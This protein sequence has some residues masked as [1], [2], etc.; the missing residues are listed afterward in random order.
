MKIFELNFG[1]GSTRMP[2]VRF[3]LGIV[4]TLS[5][6]GYTVIYADDVP[7]G[8]EDGTPL[9][10]SVSATLENNPRLLELKENRSA[11]EKDLDQAKGG[12]YPRVDLNLGYGTESHSDATT[13]TQ[14]TESDFDYRSEASLNLVQPLYQ[15]GETRSRVR[16][17]IAKL[18]SVNYRVYDNA[19]S[20][21]LDAIIA[22]LEVWRQRRLLDLTEQNIKTHEK[23]LDHI[24]E[25]QRA[26]AGS[27]ADVVQT[28][29]RLALTRSS[30]AQIAGALE[31]ARVN[32]IRVVGNAPE[33]L[34]LPKN[35]HLLAPADAEEAIAVAQ[36]CNPK[37]A[38]FS[39]DIRAAKGD[40]DVS[41][42]NYLP[43][44]N[45][46]LS[47][48]YQD[49]VESSTT[50]SHNNAAMIRARW[51]LFNGGADRAGR[52][53]ATSRKRQ[54]AAGR[55]DQYQKIT[56]Q[57][58]DTWS[59]Y[60]I[61]GQQTKTYGDAVR[62]NRQTRNAYQQQFVVGQRSL[63][64]VLDSENELFQ[65]S[66]QLVTAK[67]NEI[68]AVYRLLALSGCLLTS[69]EMDVASYDLGDVST[70]CCNNTQKIDSDGDSVPDDKD[71]CPHTPSGVAVDSEG[72]PLDGDSDGVPDYLDRCPDTKPGVTVDS[73]GCALDS[74]GDGVLNAIDQ[75]PGTPPG[76]KVDRTGC[77]KA[78]P[79]AT[80]SA[81]VTAAGTWLYKE[82]QF[83]TGKWDL[84]PDSYAV[85]EEIATWLKSKSELV[86]EIQ[87]HSDSAGRRDYNIA[88]S[89]KRAQSIIAYLVHK[90]IPA[91][92]MTPKGYGPDRPIA[93]NDTAAG[94]AKNRRVEIKPIR[95]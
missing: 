66:G 38:A 34:K 79:V 54:L 25:R 16:K 58:R 74:D 27:S 95:W 49:Q 90:G 15:G 94:R 61:A 86:V 2:L 80:Q 64:D 92:R 4:F 70:T 76:I 31:S 7:L 43:K 19:V 13:R 33:K 45:L 55:E 84:K 57:I 44:V 65:S 75:C 29:G 39:A 23:I 20:L 22:H 36:K 82:I 1:L 18:D 60:L 89:Q 48:T 32:Y 73:K 6:S 87:G 50:Y 91:T 63:L 68:V 83:E 37:L 5:V 77:P 10:L 93:G 40:I 69:L 14:G 28:K 88:L 30:R 51:N 71:R 26:G 47:S 42:S 12:Y 56:E 9:Q 53:A 67:V 52:E 81:Q 78:K 3:V 11:V 85:L 24:D 72:C 21:A 17:Q 8:A 59:Q 46:E 62:Y 35:F 41:K